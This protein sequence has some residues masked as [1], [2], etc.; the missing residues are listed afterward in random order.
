MLEVE[1]LI[2]DE[3]QEEEPGFLRGGIVEKI[4]SRVDFIF[5]CED[6]I[7]SFCK[8]IYWKSKPKSTR[9]T[10]CR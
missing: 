8:I 10:E 3:I 2:M 9:A 7:T 4:A 1:T 6:T 5:Q